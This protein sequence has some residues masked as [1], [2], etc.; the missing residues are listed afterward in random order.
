[1]QKHI[2]L[3]LDGPILD[4]RLRHYACYRDILLELGREPIDID[5]YWALKREMTGRDKVLELSG[6]ENE[7]DR[8][9]QKW[10]A[11]IERDEYLKLD[12][13]QDGAKEKLAAWKERSD[14]VVI[15]ATMRNDRSALIQQLD[16]LEISGLLDKIVVSP[17]KYGAEGKAR[18]VLDSLSRGDL[19]DGL[20]IGDTEADIHAAEFLKC[21]VWALSCGLRNAERLASLKPDFLSGYLHEVD[22]SVRRLR[23]TQGTAVNR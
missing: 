23:W 13:I 6:A 16:D 10:L 12:R 4:G 21:Q 15:L 3:D 19:S 14:I 1:M 9:L 8:F 5:R 11:N 18:A 22:L 20:W 17:H 7:Y 2:V